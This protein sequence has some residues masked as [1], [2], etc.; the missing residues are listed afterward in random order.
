MLMWG[1]LFSCTLVYGQAPVKQLT[2]IRA[3]KLFDARRG[4]MLANQAILIEGNQIKEV[5]DSATVLPHAA[6]ARTIDLTSA[7]VL[8][9]LIDAHNHI[10]GNPKNL[11]PIADLR[12]SSAQAA[13]WG[14][15][16]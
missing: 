8:P 9:G 10:L 12:M 7:T 14:V 11:S 4:R 1:L 6:G 16:N 2:L 13:L 3:G 5:G 15:R